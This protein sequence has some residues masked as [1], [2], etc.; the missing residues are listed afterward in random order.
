MQLSLWQLTTY[1]TITVTALLYENLADICAEA[2]MLANPLLKLQLKDEKQN[3]GRIKYS[4]MQHCVIQ[5]VVPNTAK[6]HRAFILTIK[7]RTTSSIVQ[8]QRTKALQS[9]K[10]SGTARPMTQHHS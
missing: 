3:A 6:D 4:G 10:M 8:T 1:R 9:F 2:Q 7:H 5:R